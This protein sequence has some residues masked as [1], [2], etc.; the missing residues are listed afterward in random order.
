M[1]GGNVAQCHSGVNSSSRCACFII[2]HMCAF[3]YT[4]LTFA[5]LTE[6]GWKPQNGELQTEW[7]VPQNI[8]KSK[9]NI[10]FFLS[11]CKHRTG[12][13][14]RKC[15]SKKK[16]RN[17]G[18]SCSCNFCQNGPQSQMETCKNKVIH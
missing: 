17:Y 6:Y 16:E 11:G 8:D 15:S 5:A 2:M 10:Y 13:I 18:P 14:M 7:E 1:S 9:S 3:T 4:I 12:Y